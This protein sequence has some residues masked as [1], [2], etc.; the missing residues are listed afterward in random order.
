MAT[1]IP[2]PWHVSGMSNIVDATF[3]SVQLGS[4]VELCI[5]VTSCFTHWVRGEVSHVT[6]FYSISSFSL[7]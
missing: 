6:I 4:K 2:K 5:K 1:P 7:C 3:T